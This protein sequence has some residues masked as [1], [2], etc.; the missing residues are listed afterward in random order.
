[1][2]H[3]YFVVVQTLIYTHASKRNSCVSAVLSLFSH[4]QLFATPWTVAPQDPL[5]MG[6]SGQK[7]CSELPCSA[8]GERKS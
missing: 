6:F 2:S 7:Y 8:P 1:M 4:I 5:S 3:Y